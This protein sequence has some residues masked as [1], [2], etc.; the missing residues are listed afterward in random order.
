MIGWLRRHPVAAFLPFQA[1]M[2][3]WNLGLLS[4]WGDE[5]YSFQTMRLPVP[6]ILRLLAHDVHPPLYYLLLY[7]WLRVPLGLSWEVQARALS[8]ICVL[9]ATVAADRWWARRLGERGRLCF[10]AIWAASPCLVLYARI[11]HSFCLQLL[12][13]TVVAGLVLRFAEGRS[14]R[15]GVWLAAGLTAAHQLSLLGYRVTVFEREKMPGGMLTAAIP[16]YR[17]PRKTQM[18]QLGEQGRRHAKGSIKMRMAPPQARPLR[19]LM[20]K[21]PDSIKTPIR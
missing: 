11:C 9:A 7:G 13:G 16:A 8:G 19:S 6:E 20:P 1:L 10:L 5:A 2:Y 14:W 15:N 21:N 4:P 18:L 17:L 12:L 3:F